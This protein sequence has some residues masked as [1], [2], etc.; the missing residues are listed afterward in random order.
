MEEGGYIPVSGDWAKRSCGLSHVKLSKNKS[1]I[2]LDSCNAGLE[3]EL[4]NKI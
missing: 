3:K 2:L 4:V 1:N